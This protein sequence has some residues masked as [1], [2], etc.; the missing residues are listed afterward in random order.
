MSQSAASIAEIARIS[1]PVPPQRATLRAYSAFQWRSIWRGSLPS[2]IGAAHLVD[3]AADGVGRVVRVA[4]PD[5]ALVGV[6]ADEDQEREGFELDRLERGDLHRAPRS[7]GSWPA[8][9]GAQARRVASA[10][11]STARSPAGIGRRQR[12]EPVDHAREPAHVDG[13]AGRAQ[14]V[15]EDLALVAER[16]EG[17][18]DDQGRREVAQVVGAVPGSA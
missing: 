9:R 4:R 8:R 11:I 18:G 14:L 5:Q 1:V 6:D 13:H 7:V 12:D 10:I 2:S 17:G 15:A 3:E 16:I